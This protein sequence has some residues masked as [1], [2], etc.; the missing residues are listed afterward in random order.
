MSYISW[1]NHTDASNHNHR[2][3][4]IK[5]G[6]LIDLALELGH[7]GVG[8][9]DHAVL[10]NHIKA[11]KHLKKIEKD[12]KNK[13]E[14]CTKEE[15]EDLTIK[16]NNVQNFKLGLGIE[17]YLVNENEVEEARANNTPTKFYHYIMIPKNKKGY[18][19]IVK[20]S[21][22]SWKNS[23]YHRGMERIPT[24]KNDLKE[25]IG[26]EKGNVIVS[27]ACLGSEFA[28]YVLELH[29]AKKLNF[30]S[31]IDLYKNK[32]EEFIKFNLDLFGEDFYIEIQP[33]NEEEQIEY[34]KLAYQ[35]AKY[36]NI[37]TIVTTDSHYL[38]KEDKKT[39]SD[40]LKSQNAERETDDFYKYTYLMS[41]E[42][43]KEKLKY[44]TEKQIEE[45]IENTLEISNK[46]EQFD[47]Y[48]TTQVPPAHTQLQKNYKSKFYS[49]DTL[50]TDYIYIK[51]YLESEFEIDRILLQQIEFGMDSLKEE[52]NQVN[53]ERLNKELEAMWFVSEGLCQRLSSYYVLT[54][55]IVDLIWTVSLVGVSR[56][57]AGA[58]YICYLLKITQINPIEYKLD[59]WRH[60]DKN[61][62]ELADIDIDSSSAQRDNILE[63]IK[64]KYGYNKV[65]TIGTFKTEKTSSIIHTICRGMGIDKNKAEYLSL[66]IPKEGMTQKTIKESLELYEIEESCTKFVNELKLIDS[67]YNG[68]IDNLLKTQGLICGKSSHASGVYLYSDDFT[69]YNALMKTKKGL[70]ITQYDMLDSDYQ[71]GLKLDFLT[72]EGL[73]R[74]QKCLD[75]LIEHK[76]IEWQGTLRDTYNKYLHPTVID[77]T[78]IK[79]YEA[80]KNGEILDAFQYES[81]AGANTI[82]KIQPNN[83]RELMEGNALMRLNPK[84]TKLPIDTYV[85]HKKDINKWYKDM[86]NK[87]L[88]EAE[89]NCLKEHLL[90]SYGVAPTQEAIMRLSMDNRISGF[91][92]IEANKLRK[93]VAKA[94]AKHL[95]EEVYSMMKQKAESLGNREIFIEYVWNRFIVP[96]LNYSFSEPH[97]AAYTLILVQEMN[98]AVK[99]P[100]I[101]WNVACLT[102]QAGML[103]DDKQKGTDYGA[104]AKAIGK[105]EQ[106]FVLPPCINKAKMEFTPLKNENKVVYSLNAI[107]GIGADIVKQIINNRPYKSFD[108]FLDK[109]YYT[110]IITTTKI[111]TLIKAG[112]FDMFDKDRKKLMQHFI[113][114]TAEQKTTLTTS[115]IP[116]LLENNIIP[117]ELLPYAYLCLFK[118]QVF[119]KS[120]ISETLNKTTNLYTI[121]DKYVDIFK[122]NYEK[123]FQSS[124]DI[125]KKGKMCLNNKEFNKIYK[126][127]ITPLKKWL[128]QR[129][130]VEKYNLYLKSLIWDKY[131]KGNIESWEMESICFYTNKHELDYIPLEQ[132]LSIKKFNDLPAIP[133]VIVKTTSRGRKY[134]EFVISLIAGTIIE[135]N[136]NKN[137][138]TILT[139]HKE[140]IDV[141]LTKSQ[142]AQ[143]DKSD[144]H[145]DSWLKKGN[146][147]TVL[148]YRDGEMFKAKNYTNSI[149]SNIIMLVK[150]Y[151]YN[152]NKPILVLDKEVGEVYSE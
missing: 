20:I 21:T 133:E 62:I 149:Y 63:L 116:K 130:T 45:I 33:A 10:S 82:N 103:S 7:K 14:N 40:F 152:N 23:F 114:K 105:M 74:I 129:E 38:Y 42:E 28:T 147:I 118:K 125:D 52:Y 89:I 59:E 117:K 124:I 4:I 49:I 9:T 115:S 72:L 5:V 65:L 126:T 37:K 139:K 138:I 123:Y 100:K 83:F 22:Q 101:Y 121:P 61:K 143:F 110:K 91:N 87:G 34:N 119:N 102:V 53:L 80:L 46:I 60:L 57:S 75:L 134:N 2:D 71:G 67:E 140:V 148:G 128:E 99:Y 98:L 69:E 70:W 55:E 150:G 96:Q 112:A 144:T 79:M 24:Y 31:K 58:F 51:K 8:I 12:F 92:L 26:E 107:N 48:K 122:Q 19:Q 141:Q 27:T 25:I 132:T 16:Y 146:I 43:I 85:E 36:Y 41:K 44:F 127:T 17:L 86:E 81:I 73:D 64:Q 137:T 18:R 84:N 111:Y 56:G 106:G 113:N 1:H 76:E 6:D 88:N 35:I 15:R 142:F 97:L 145:S 3:S 39:H 95:I 90:Q 78:D 108:D 136:K 68:F 131:C 120:N 104:I 77:K 47:L 32:I 94:Y 54:K 66:M 30:V 11:I 29:K 93:S 135:R 109:C 151:D 50:N 13:L